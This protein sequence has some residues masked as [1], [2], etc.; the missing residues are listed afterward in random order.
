MHETSIDIYFIWGVGI[1]LLLYGIGLSIF[2]GL[3]GKDFLWVWG[4][5]WSG[6]GLG[7]LA[8]SFTFCGIGV[9]LLGTTV[10]RFIALLLI[11][12]A[13]L[14]VIRGFIMY[15][16]SSRREKRAPKTGITMIIVSFILILLFALSIV[17]MKN[18]YISKNQANPSKEQ[19]EG[20]TN[21]TV[22]TITGENWDNYFELVDEVK[23]DK[24]EKGEVTAVYQ[25]S[26]FDLKDEYQS[27]Q[28]GIIVERYVG[29]EPY[30]YTYDEL[31]LIEASGTIYLKAE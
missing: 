29:E 5:N 4:T 17:M 26:W 1:F 16:K 23:Y 12:C 19:M 3:S 10:V 9:A 8:N 6:G 11:V 24:N 14:S 18:D 27:R 13:L 28:K 15:L 25:E 2:E 31:K 7:G 30:M 22:L 20:N 21:G